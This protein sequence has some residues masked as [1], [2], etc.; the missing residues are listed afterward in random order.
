MTYFFL[1]Q[2]ALALVAGMGHEVPA[3]GTK[4]RTKIPTAMRQLAHLARLK[5]AWR[6]LCAREIAAH[7]EFTL[8][9]WRAIACAFDLVLSGDGEAEEPR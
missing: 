3:R 8:C 4:F 7:V 9:H 5:L 1:Y 2:V 6:I